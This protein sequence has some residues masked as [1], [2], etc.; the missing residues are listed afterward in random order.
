VA[1]SGNP[2]TGRKSPSDEGPGPPEARPAQ[3]GSGRALDG[4]RARPSAS[5][6]VVFAH[7]ARR[8]SPWGELTEP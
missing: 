5:E 6:Y 8:V 4:Q 1:G 7:G 3:Q 2:V